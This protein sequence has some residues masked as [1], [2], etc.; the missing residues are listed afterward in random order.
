MGAF[1]LSVIPRQNTGLQLEQW[2]ATSSLQFDNQT[3]NCFCHF[4]SEV[5]L[6]QLRSWLGQSHWARALTL[7]GISQL[8]MLFQKQPGFG[9]E[10]EDSLPLLLFTNRTMFVFRKNE[11][12][13]NCL[14]RMYTLFMK[15]LDSW[16]HQ[17][18][19]FPHLTCHK[20]EW[21][22]KGLVGKVIWHQ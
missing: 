4:P 22:N 1:L 12:K 2:K 17:M 6:V 10:F 16:L 19:Q 21:H 5:A 11:L 14:R 9:T 13:T 18:H 7:L 8:R 15:S 20:K 3:W